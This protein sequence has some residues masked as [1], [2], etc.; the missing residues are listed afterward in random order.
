MYDLADSPNA[1]E[2]ERRR[3]LAVMIALVAWI[4]S[5]Q[6]TR[7][8][9]VL[10]IATPCPLL[11]AIPVAIIGAISLCGTC[12]EDLRTLLRRAQAQ[13]AVIEADN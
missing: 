8:L 4:L 2:R 10:V 11:I 7:F 1:P 6:A 5:G 3:R 13:V 12:V 9:A